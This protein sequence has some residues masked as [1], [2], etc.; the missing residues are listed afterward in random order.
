MARRGLGRV[1]GL[2]QPD[3]PSEF[4]PIIDFHVAHERQN[5]VRPSFVFPRLNRKWEL[6]RADAAA[7]S[8]TRR[9]LALICTG[10]DD[11]DAELYTLHSPKNFLPTAATQMNFATRELNVIGHWSSNSRM[12]ERY[13]RSVCASELLLRNTIIQKMVAGWNMVASF[14][15]PE[16]VTGAAR[17]GKDPGMQASTIGVPSQTLVDSGLV[18]STQ[19]VPATTDTQHSGVSEDIVPSTQGSPTPVGDQQGGLSEALECE[20]TP[21]ELKGETP[22]VSPNS[23]T[24]P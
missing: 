1:L 24:G 21:C 8:S 9:K 5:G 22:L 17:I 16:S 11:P 23:T 18:P 4:S 20:T 6:E 19:G 3:P 14:H 13:D 10:L 2:E 15:L 12:N 7:Y